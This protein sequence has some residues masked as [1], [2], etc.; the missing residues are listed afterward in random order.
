MDSSLVV[1]REKAMA[2]SEY[3]VAQPLPKRL[4]E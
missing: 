2:V 3:D 1:Y 4:F